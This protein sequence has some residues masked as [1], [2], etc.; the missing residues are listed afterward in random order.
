[1]NFGASASKGRPLSSPTTP[2]PARHRSQRSSGDHVSDPRSAERHRGRWPQPGRPVVVIGERG[3]GK[4]HLM[5]ALYHAVNDAAS[6]GAWLNSWATTLGDPNIGKIALR[7]GMLVIGESLHR[8]RYKFLWDL[9]FERHPH[10]DLHQGQV[11]RHG[12]GQDRH[13]LRQAHPRAVAAHADDAA[14]GRIPDLV[15]RPDQHQAVPLEELGVQLHPD[16][17]RDCQ[18]AAGSAGARDLGSQRRQRCLS[19]GASRQSGRHRLQGGRQCRAYPAGSAADVA[20]PPVR[21]PPAD[22]RRHH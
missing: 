8:Q 14:A 5:A 4:S 2:T 16:P 12:R 3:L 17:V 22:C 19:A 9:L 15:R 1:M 13:P 21:Q 6:T 10:G 20:A 11:G 18:G 7:S